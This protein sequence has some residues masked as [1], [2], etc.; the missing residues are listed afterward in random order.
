[1]TIVARPSPLPAW[2]PVD[3]AGAQRRALAAWHEARAAEVRPDPGASMTREE[4]LDLSRTSEVRERAHAA[5]LE[6]LGAP[7]AASDRP[8][9]VVAH[10]HGWLRQ[11]LVAQLEAL[12]V[13]VVASVED[14]ADAV[15]AVVVAQP[16]LLLVEDRLPS[17]RGRTV[18][19]AARRYA[20]HAVR[21]VQVG[22][23]V[24]EDLSAAEPAL[25]FTRATR[26]ADMAGRMAGALARP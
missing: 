22:D 15:G 23:D 2:T 3:R 24:V 18:L 4:R 6:R 7:L 17:M 12:G 5:V 8:A 26:P 14:G 13:E 25:V 19:L 16:D 11:G 10:R 9:A 1:M 21:A 20:P